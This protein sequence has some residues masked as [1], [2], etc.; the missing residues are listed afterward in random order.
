MI[1][2]APCYLLQTFRARQEVQSAGSKALKPESLWELERKETFMGLGPLDALKRFPRRLGHG[3]RFRHH[4][5]VHCL[6]LSKL[7]NST[8]RKLNSKRLSDSTVVTLLLS[9]R[10]KP[11][12]TLPVWVLKSFLLAGSSQ[13]PRRAEHQGNL[14]Q[15]CFPQRAFP[16]SPEVGTI[17]WFPMFCKLNPLL[18]LGFP[19]WP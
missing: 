3:T 10:E 15:T 11:K 12:W 6:R 8:Q 1:V 16:V 18:K 17:H 2:Q 4:E 19:T 14:Y 9:G 5:P 7:T 13:C